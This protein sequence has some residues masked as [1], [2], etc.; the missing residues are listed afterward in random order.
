MRPDAALL[1]PAFPLALRR[2]FFKK[3][4]Y[5]RWK[6]ARNLFRFSSA[7]IPHKSFSSWHL[8]KRGNPLR[9]FSEKKLKF[10]LKLP[11]KTSGKPEST[12]GT[13]ES[14]GAGTRRRQVRVTSWRMAQPHGVCTRSLVFAKAAHDEN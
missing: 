10:P 6:T 4:A 1:F 7:H 14:T 11:I 12:S 8:G 3:S 13:V 2:G 9:F 5:M